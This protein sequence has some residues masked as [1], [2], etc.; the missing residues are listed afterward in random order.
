MRNGIP[1]VPFPPNRVIE[2]SVHDV[3][4][5]CLAAIGELQRTEPL[6][7]GNRFDILQSIVSPTR[8]NPFS[9]VALIVSH[10]A[11]VLF[12]PSPSFFSR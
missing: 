8:Q 12:E 9:E 2:D 3:T 5:F 11:K 10:V 4:D 7:N 6:F 1:V